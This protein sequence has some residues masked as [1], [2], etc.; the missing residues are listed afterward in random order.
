MVVVAAGVIERRAPL[1]IFVESQ[2][3]IHP[4]PLRSQQTL[5]LNFFM[6]R[7]WTPGVCSTFLFRIYKRNATN[8][9]ENAAVF[10][11]KKIPRSE[12]NNSICQIC[13]CDAPLGKKRRAPA[14]ISALCGNFIYM[15]AIPTQSAVIAVIFDGDHDLRECYLDEIDL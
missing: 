10:A 14:A 11:G 4:L 5:S 1:L 3:A 7:V 9:F 6:R 15:A 12:Q 13:N 2:G 8:L